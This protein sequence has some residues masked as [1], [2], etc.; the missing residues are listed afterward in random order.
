[1]K[2]IY[3]VLK[4]MNSDRDSIKEVSIVAN[5]YPT[6]KG[7]AIEVWMSPKFVHIKVYDINKVEGI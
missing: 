4:D 1:M 6:E 2:M 5:K 3:E 7:F